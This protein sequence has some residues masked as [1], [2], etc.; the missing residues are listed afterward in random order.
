MLNCSVN[1]EV[2]CTGQLETRPFR[3]SIKRECSDSCR[4]SEVEQHTAGS[5]IAVSELCKN[6]ESANNFLLFP[7]ITPP[8]DLGGTVNVQES[9]PKR[10]SVKTESSTELAQQFVQEPGLS[11]RARHWLERPPQLTSGK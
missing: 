8:R 4:E 1:R 2:G 11:H 9:R 5:A 3:P 7:G 6:I 10:A